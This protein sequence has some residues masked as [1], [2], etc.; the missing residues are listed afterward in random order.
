MQ[1]KLVKKLPVIML[2]VMIIITAAVLVAYYSGNQELAL[3]TQKIHFYVIAVGAIISLFLF[4][5]QRW[6]NKKAE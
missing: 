3:L 1:G 2:A 4:F 6:Q 5:K